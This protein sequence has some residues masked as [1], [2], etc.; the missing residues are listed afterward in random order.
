MPKV[1]TDPD[2]VFFFFALPVEK[3]GSTSVLLVFLR[4][5]G[6]QPSTV[7]SDDAIR[8]GL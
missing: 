8:Q 3:S 6:F 1:A 2:E 7:K 5:V 4:D